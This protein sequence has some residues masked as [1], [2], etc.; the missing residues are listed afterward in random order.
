MSGWHV[1]KKQHD[2]SAEEKITHSTAS[3]KALVRTPELAAGIQG[4]RIR[5]GMWQ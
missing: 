3:A 4:T 5:S 2:N 1:S